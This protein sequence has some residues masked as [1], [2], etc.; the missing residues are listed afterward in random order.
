[1]C[2]SAAAEASIRL[3]DRELRIGESADEAW[4][5]DR[6]ITLH[7]LSREQHAQVPS[8]P[9]LEDRRDLIRDA[10]TA[11]STAPCGCPLPHALPQTDEL[12]VWPPNPHARHVPYDTGIRRNAYGRGRRGGAGVAADRS[13][14]VSA[15]RGITVVVMCIWHAADR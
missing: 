4:L 13:P 14:T 10:L 1:V 2:R 9:D 11:T 12:P 6:G 15:H 7:W 3:L 8:R 5:R